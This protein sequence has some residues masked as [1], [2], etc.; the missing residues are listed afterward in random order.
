MAAAARMH[1]MIPT[2]PYRSL[3]P[4]VDY[5]ECQWRV[6]ADCRVQGGPRLPGAEANAGNELPFTSRRP[7]RDGVAVASHRVSIGHEAAD[8]DLDAL[9]RRIDVP[10]RAA[11]HALFTHYVPGLERLAQLERGAPHGDVAKHGESKFE[12]RRKP[13]DTHIEAGKLLLPD[14][15]REILEYEMRQEP[16]VME[17]RS[18][19]RQP[20]RGIW[21]GPEARHERTQQQLLN[22]AHACVRRHFKGAHFK[23][24][25]TATRGIG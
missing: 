11:R 5:I 24:T 17:L 6:N 20:R 13:V 19:T 15:I 1:H 3:H 23:K 10:H 8:L 18:P 16:P 21:L 7:Q 25:E 9:E 12:V 2:T 22:Q 14:D 4:G